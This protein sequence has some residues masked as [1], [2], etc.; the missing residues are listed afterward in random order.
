MAEFRIPMYIEHARESSEGGGIA[1][2][3]AGGLH[4]TSTEQDQNGSY[5]MP[6]G[7]GAFTIR[8]PIPLDA[9]L[10]DVELVFTGAFVGR[11]QTVQGSAFWA[12]TGTAAG[13]TLANGTPAFDE[14]SGNTI[15]V[16]VAVGA[17]VNL[18]GTRV[19]VRA[20][21]RR[22]PNGGVAPGGAD[23]PQATSEL[24][25]MFANDA[26]NDNPATGSLLGLL[27]REE[28][29]LASQAGSFN[30]QR[31]GA[32]GGIVSVQHATMGYADPW[33][34]TVLTTADLGSGPGQIPTD[35]TLWQGA[36]FLNQPQTFVRLGG[37][38]IRSIGAAQ[39]W[40]NNAT[41]VGPTTP[42]TDIALSA[43][44]LFTVARAPTHSTWWVVIDGAAQELTFA[45][46]VGSNLQRPVD[47]WNNVI[48]PYMTAMSAAGGPGTNGVVAPDKWTPPS[49]PLQPGGIGTDAAVGPAIT[50]EVDPGQGVFP[51]IAP[52]F[53]AVV[54]RQRGQLPRRLSFLTYA[55]L[56]HLWD[57]ASPYETPILTP[58]PTTPAP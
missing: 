20:F 10:L 2:A 6:G 55:R 39:R 40:F 15:S 30:V 54:F 8:L 53:P 32:A 44:L 56:L 48:V 23:W 57:A 14:N 29:R 26:Q 18:A 49:G 9:E 1:P 34:R 35:R 22:G 24:C 43:L 28:R 19:K 33:G 47:I 12:L 17:I 16:A 5:A 21:W 25:G 45:H 50:W 46:P 27:A 31:A 4:V 41:I 37:G 36:Q 51:V 11:L 58:V 52:V 7:G 3:D 38:R 13:A 42:L